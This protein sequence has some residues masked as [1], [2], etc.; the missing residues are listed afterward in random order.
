MS[1]FIKESF[2]FVWGV[3]WAD[4]M[5]GYGAFWGILVYM[6][7][8]THTYIHPPTKKTK[9]KTRLDVVAAEEG[10]HPLKRGPQ[11]GVGVARLKSKNKC[12]GLWRLGMRV[13]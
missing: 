12:W 5:D 7:V 3:G 13:V 4:K 11:L 9:Q 1:Y 2:G 6:N 10:E 8:H